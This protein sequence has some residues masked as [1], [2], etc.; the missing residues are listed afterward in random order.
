[1]NGTSGISGWHWLGIGTGVAIVGVA[2]GDAYIILPAL[3]FAVIG[4]QAL[5]SRAKN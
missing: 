2:E 4:A 5:W 3:F 1:M